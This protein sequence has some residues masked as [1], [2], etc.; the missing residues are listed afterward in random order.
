MGLDDWQDP[1]ASI[2]TISQHM[3]VDSLPQ[4]SFFFFG[5]IRG[6]IYRDLLP[7]KTGNEQKEGSGGMILQPAV[8]DEE[9]NPRAA[10]NVRLSFFVSFWAVRTS[11]DRLSM[12]QA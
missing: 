10:N 3:V 5:C 1:A 11:L 6:I 4:P 8:S 12:D 7:R 9:H 2:P